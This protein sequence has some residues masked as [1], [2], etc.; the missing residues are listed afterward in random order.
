[1]QLSFSFCPVL[2]HLILQWKIWWSQISAPALVCCSSLQTDEQCHPDVVIC[3]S[4]LHILLGRDFPCSSEC[5]IS[6]WQD[7][8]VMQPFYYSGQVWL[9]YC[10]SHHFFISSSLPPPPPPHPLVVCSFSSTPPPCFSFSFL[11]WLN[12][13]ILRRRVCG[14][15]GWTCCLG[16]GFGCSPEGLG[17][18]KETLGE[19]MD[20]T[21]KD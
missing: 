12:S 21:E 13:E 16:R 17:R 11:I 3:A 15:S 14:V 5:M 6:A 10:I 7:R 2:G 18:N 9:Q 19:Q 4:V 1:M 20:I 8:G